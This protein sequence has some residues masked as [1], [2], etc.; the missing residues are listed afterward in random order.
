VGAYFNEPE[1][2]HLNAA[3][4]GAGAR[5]KPIGLSAALDPKI[6]LL[7]GLPHSEWRACRQDQASGD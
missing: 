1:I 2:F 7:A 6:G 3:P 5:D 4:S